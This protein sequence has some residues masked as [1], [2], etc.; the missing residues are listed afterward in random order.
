M[1]P[2]SQLVEV[3]TRIF[4]SADFYAVPEQM[5]HLVLVLSECALNRTL[6][7]LQGCNFYHVKTLRRFCKCILQKSNVLKW[8]I[9]MDTCQIIRKKMNKWMERQKER[10]CFQPHGESL[11]DFFWLVFNMISNQV[12][13]YGIFGRL[14]VW[15]CVCASAWVAYHVLVA[16][17]R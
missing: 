14:Y 12:N 1:V 11:N 8:W 7:K 2:H 3:C 10:R 16:I 9:C 5:S 15:V 4:S 6:C 17:S 13:T